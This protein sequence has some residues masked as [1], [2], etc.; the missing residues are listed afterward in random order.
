M[1]NA[2]SVRWLST[3]AL[4]FLV[5]LPAM[6]QKINLVERVYET[7]SKETNPVV[8][9]AKMMTEATEK[10]AEDLIKEIIGEAKFSRNRALINEKIMKFSS[11]YIPYTKPGEITPLQPEGF[12]MT[13]TLKVSVDDLQKMLLENGL[14]YAN[15]GTPIV[16]P[17]VRFT[18]KVSFKSFGWW[19]EPETPQKV[20]LQKEDRN[21]EDVLKTAFGRNSFYSLK[22]L[23]TKYYSFLPEAFHQENL[24]VE[25]LQTIAQ[26]L[27]A[28]IIL[29]GDV[30]ISRSQ[31][32]SEAFTIQMQLSAIQV[33]NGR[34]IAEVARQFETD[35]GGYETAVGKKL[36]E[37]NEQVAQDLSSQVLEAWQRVAIG[38]SLYKLVIHGRLPLIQQEALKDIV[39]NKVR[40][41]KNIRERLISSDSM[42]YEV[43][44]ALGPK[45]FATKVPQLDLGGIKLVLESSSATEAV[46]RI[47]R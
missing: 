22:P 46:Y 37:V 33:V 38:A 45:E 5:A 39:K 10:A 9:K 12:K 30:T 16:L 18:D 14:F 17:F 19:S 36:K 29:S 35:L 6:T 34:V 40:E 23:V 13:L 24:R 27:G 1:N 21:F 25:D 47:A 7:Q 2:N 26:K 42:I 28:Q 44:S 8:A 41:V 4:S 32:R 31:E 3:L 43:D 11:R 20:F 15:D